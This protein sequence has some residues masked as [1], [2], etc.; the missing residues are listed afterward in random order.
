MHAVNCLMNHIKHRI[1]YNLFYLIHFY[2]QFYKKGS[3]RDVQIV[4][5]TIYTFHECVLSY[6][7]FEVF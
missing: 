2:Q 5:F 4:H 7:I 1:K 6:I 3:K